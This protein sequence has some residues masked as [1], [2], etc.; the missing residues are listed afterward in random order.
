MSTYIE[1]KCKEC[2]KKYS[3][4]KTQEK[5]WDKCPICVKKATT[6]KKPADPLKSFQEVTCSKCQKVYTVQ[7]KAVA[8]FKQCPDCLKKGTKNGHETGSENQPVH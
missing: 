8:A 3:I 4:L 2:A 6:P 7:K 1:V 5:K